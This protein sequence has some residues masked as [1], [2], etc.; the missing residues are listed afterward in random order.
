MRPRMTKLKR[1]R[2]IPHAGIILWMSFFLL[3]LTSCKSTTSPEVEATTARMTVNNDCGIAVDIY[4]DKNFQFSVEYQESE[5]ILDISIGEHEVEAK[6]KVTEIVLSSLSVELLEP[7]EY[8]LTIQ[9]EAS[10]HITNEYGES[11]N[12]YGDGD[13]LSD[14]GSLGTLIIENVLYGVHL[15]EAKKVS[16]GTTVASISIDFAENKAYFWTINQ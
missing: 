15:L 10:V 3:A 2:I 14:I 16:D 12:I 8:I 6:N 11:L 1:C 4:M 13:L 5:T 7:R 9:S